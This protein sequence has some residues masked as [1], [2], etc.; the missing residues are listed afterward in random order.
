MARLIYFTTS[1][2]PQHLASLACWRADWTRT[3]DVHLYSNRPLA[4]E[5]R[6]T[7]RQV[8]AR[9]HNI[10]LDVTR[11]GHQLGAIRAF[12]RAK[13]LFLRY[14][15]VLRTNPDVLVLAPSAFTAWMRKGSVGAVLANCNP[16]TRCRADCPDALVHTDFQIFRPE[17]VH[18]GAPLAANAEAHATRVMARMRGRARWIQDRGFR[19]RSCRIR[20]GVREGRAAVVHARSHVSACRR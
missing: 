5:W 14:E 7:L 3:Y 8:P 16:C 6:A 4:P 17:L 18:W 19:D 20:A 11:A 1:G 13:P 2:S 15:W 9:R 12:V 10:T